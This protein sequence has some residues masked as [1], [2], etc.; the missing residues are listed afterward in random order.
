M[1][2]KKIFKK[3]SHLPYHDVITIF[4]WCGEKYLNKQSHRK[5]NI[6]D[7]CYLWKKSED[8]T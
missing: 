2:L 7:A 1:E 3:R 6:S 4:K 8:K 5:L